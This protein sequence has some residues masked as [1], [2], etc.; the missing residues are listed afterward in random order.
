VRHESDPTRDAPDVSK[1]LAVGLTLALSTLGFLWAGTVVDGWLETDPVFTLLGAFFGAA[2]GFYYM[3]HH[4]VTVPGRRA[5][6]RKCDAERER[7]DRSG[8]EGR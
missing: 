2:A 8:P 3:I 7:A 6:E 5:A 1:Y 4:L